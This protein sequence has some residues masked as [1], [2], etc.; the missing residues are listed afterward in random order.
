MNIHFYLNNEEET[1]IMSMYDAAVEP[2]K[3]GDRIRLDVD[4]LVPKDVSGLAP[5]IAR[6]FQLNNNELRNLFRLKTIE[7]VRLNR[8]ARFNK[9]NDAIITIEYHCEIVED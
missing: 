3:E 4:D 5:E 9:M 8:Y 6:E 1:Q 2:F 7:I